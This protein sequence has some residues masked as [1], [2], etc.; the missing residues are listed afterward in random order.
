MN[1][2]QIIQGK[3]GIKR[4]A[5]P[6]LALV[7]LARDPVIVCPEVYCLIHLDDVCE[8]GSEVFQCGV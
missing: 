8:A 3:G 2:H 6:H 4:N 1:I 7:I 5:F